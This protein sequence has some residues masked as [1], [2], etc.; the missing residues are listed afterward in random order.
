MRY[1]EG[2]EEV[3]EGGDDVTRRGR[4]LFECMALVFRPVVFLDVCNVFNVLRDLGG[5]RTIREEAIA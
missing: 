1:G 2:G 5:A 3:E 4:L